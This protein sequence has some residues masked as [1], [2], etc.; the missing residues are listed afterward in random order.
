[1]ARPTIEVVRA[2]EIETFARREHDAAQAGA[3]IPISISRACAWAKNP[4]AKPDDIVLIVARLAGRCAGYLG[5]LPGRLRVYDRVEPMSWLSTF[6]VPEA[7]RDQAIGGLLLMRALSLGRTLAASDSSDHAA[8][9][10]K[11]VGFAPPQELSYFTLDLQRQQNWLGLPLRL[12]RRTLL[13][14]QIRVPNSLDRAINICAR[15]T[16]R[17]LL[18]LVA[19]VARRRLGD[20]QVRSLEHLPPG[21]CRGNG[22][23]YFVRDRALLEWMLACSWLTTNRALSSA[24][25]Y[26]DDFREASYHRVVQLCRPGSGAPAGWAILYFDARG[27]QRRLQ[28]LDYELDRP[29][30]GAALIAAA[31]QAGAQAG[32]TQ[33]YLPAVCADGLQRL[34]GLG[35]LFSAEMRKAYYRPHAASIARD[36]LGEIQ[37]T[38]AD[39]DLSFA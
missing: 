24:E 5:L 3:V 28:V 13:D 35:K 36:A 18:P 19:A 15:A 11:A 23:V 7:L 4:H 22:N 2:S 9:A 12:I 14:R 31:L 10:F 8:Q 6:F 17:L 1:M 27:A 20:W 26:F 39:G 29:A 30:G 16:A 21:L 37:L 25:Y 33:L 32:A 34:G 38:Y